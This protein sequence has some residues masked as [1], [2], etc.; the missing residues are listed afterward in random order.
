MGGSGN[1]ST[2]RAGD[3]TGLSRALALQL[4]W[5]WDHHLSP[6]LEGMTD[7]EYHWEPAA[8]AW[9]LRPHGTAGRPD[10]EGAV[11]AGSGDWRVDF[12]VPE[13]SPSPVTTIAWRMAHVLMGVLGVRRAGHFGG[14]AMDY[15]TYDYPVTADQAC[16]RLGAAAGAWCDAVE[17]LGPAELD[18]PV[19]EAEGPWVEHSMLKL[20]LHIHREVIHH[21]A[22]MCLLRDLYRADRT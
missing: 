19:G 11:Q 8:G 3:S 22:E 14:P 12:A 9:G 16:A 20:V 1:V 2:G 13:P 15:S 21:G 10:Y 4:R 18:E 17:A 6:R 7:E 5:H